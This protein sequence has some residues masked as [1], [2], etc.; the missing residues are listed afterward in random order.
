MPIITNVAK[1]WNFTVK[2]N[3]DKFTNVNKA[4][5]YITEYYKY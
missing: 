2:S 1:M 5:K 4:Y 3:N